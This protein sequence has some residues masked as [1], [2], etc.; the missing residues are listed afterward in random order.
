VV[1]VSFTNITKDR[2]GFR[3]KL[4]KEIFTGSF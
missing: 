2:L 4:G 3:R 1:M